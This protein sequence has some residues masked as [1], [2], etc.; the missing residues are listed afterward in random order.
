MEKIRLPASD[1]KLLEECD[2]ETFRAGGK[3]G[4]HVNKTD[5]A[6]RLRHRPTGIAV[7]CQQERSQYQNKLICLHK[8]RAKVAALNYIP[9]PRKATKPTAAA[10]RGKKKAKITQSRKKMLRSKDWS[11]ED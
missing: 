11:D 2:V 6:V 3:G 10:K 9:K 4:Q 7:I 5:S 8:L 1:E